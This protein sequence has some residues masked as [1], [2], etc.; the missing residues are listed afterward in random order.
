MR[1]AKAATLGF[2]AFMVL[3]CGGISIPSIPPF[4]S[5][6]TFPPGV[7]PTPAPGSSID[8]AGGLCRLLSAAEV[9]ATMG[10]TVTITEGTSDSCTYTAAQTFATINVRTESGDLTSAHFL[11]GDT[12]KEITIGQYSGLSGTFVGSP[13]VYV[14]RGNDQLVLQGVLVGADEAAMAKLVQL[15]TTAASRW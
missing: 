7:I 13:L 10:A 6:P 2:V 8:T 3:A 5:I 9:S 1:F 14:Q 11:L 15:A 4:P 12:A